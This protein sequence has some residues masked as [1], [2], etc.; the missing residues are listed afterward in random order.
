MMLFGHQK[1]R[2]AEFDTVYHVLESMADLVSVLDE[3]GRY[4]YANRAMIQKIGRSPVGTYFDD[5]SNYLLGFSSVPN[6]RHT[7]STVVR[8]E[9]IDDEYYSVTTSPVLYE[10]GRIQAFVEVYHDISAKINL[11]IDLV[12]TNRKMSD[13]IQFARSIQKKILPE[14]MDMG[15]VHFKAQYFPSERLSGD[16]Y[17]IIAVDDHRF[18]FYIADVMG[19]GVTASMMTIF[20]RQTMR[21]LINE[22]PTPNVVLEGLRDAFCELDLGDSNY[23]TLFYCLYDT[24]TGELCHTNAGHSAMPLVY[25]DKK[26]EFIRQP[27]VPVS[28]VFRAISYKNASMTL[29]TGDHVLLYTDGVTETV[30]IEGEQFGEERLLSLVQGAEEDILRMILQNV[31]RFRWGE[32]QDDIALILMRIDEKGVELCN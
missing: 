28:P 1:D 15:N 19:H 5:A 4:I 25:N 23:F 7:K 21:S 26:A 16:F 14:S 12:N 24:H 11:T 30:N 9:R 6:V 17:D 27:G 31:T 13:D 22:E 32:M 3:D 10:D 18:V 2:I 29:K 8:E 20:V